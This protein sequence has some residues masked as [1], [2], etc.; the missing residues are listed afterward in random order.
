M[1]KQ[2]TAMSWLESF[3][4]S[5]VAAGGVG[6]GLA[7]A[8]W[9][10]LG[11]TKDYLTGRERQG[12]FGQAGTADAGRF[13][14][15]MLGAGT[16]VGLGTH[17]HIPQTSRLARMALMLGGMG[18]GSFLG[19]RQGKQVGQE[20]FPGSFGDRAHRAINSIL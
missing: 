14:G 2:S 19:H 13:L 3:P 5:I 6:A 9:D 20:L 18:V 12:E 11:A 10:T 15:G 8:P 7:T 17:W 4:K 1:V 16:A